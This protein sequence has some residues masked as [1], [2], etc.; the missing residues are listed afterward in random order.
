MERVFPAMVNVPVVI[1]VWRGSSLSFSERVKPAPNPPG[2][3][4]LDDISVC[5]PIEYT[6]TT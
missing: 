2:T 6:L 3:R 5:V 4:F 1:A